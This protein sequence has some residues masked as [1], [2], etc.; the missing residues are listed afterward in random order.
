ML[1]FENLASFSVYNFCPQTSKPT[2][3]QINKAGFLRFLRTICRCLPK[4]FRDTS[5][6][7]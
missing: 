4:T 6:I 2:N 1:S 7:S 5:E 3:Q